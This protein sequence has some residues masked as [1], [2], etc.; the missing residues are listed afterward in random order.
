MAGPEDEYGKFFEEIQDCSACWAAEGRRT[1][2]V[3]WGRPDARIVQVSQAPSARA[4]A[5]GRPFD[6]ASGR[7]LREWYG[8]SEAVFYDPGLFYMTSMARCHPGRA[9]GGG[10]L[11]PPRA[12]A[13]RWLL[14]EISL[15]DPRAYVLLGSLPA[16]FLLGRGGFA[17]RVFSD[18]RLFGKPCY[19]LPHPSPR[20][21]AWLARH[22][23]FVSRRL[24]GIREA[25]ARIL[26][27]P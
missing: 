26:A 5:A 27:G 17:S 1:R 15:L 24:P 23:D 20:N 22:P 18:Q 3:I 4:Q 10:D 2:P 11:R 19:V 8:I 7:R 25:L 21:A 16:T 9:P 6:D 13:D 14:R 12:C